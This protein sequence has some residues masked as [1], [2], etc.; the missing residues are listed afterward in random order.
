MHVVQRLEHVSKGGDRSI[1]GSCRVHFGS[2]RR[3]DCGPV[4]LVAVER[5][6]VDQRVDGIENGAGRIRKSILSGDRR[7][8]QAGY[9]EQG[10]N[11]ERTGRAE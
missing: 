4:R 3:F 9:A 5:M 11:G 2:E 6:L 1:D 7:T 8:R 10:E